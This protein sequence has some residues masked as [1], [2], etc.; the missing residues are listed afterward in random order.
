MDKN[1]NG[2]G[3][4]KI[5]INFYGSKLKDPAGTDRTKIRLNSIGQG[6]NLMWG[7]NYWFIVNSGGT[8]I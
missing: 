3:A 7:G 8:V 2:G 5:D 1:S 6:V 4:T